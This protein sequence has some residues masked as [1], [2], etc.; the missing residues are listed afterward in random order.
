[1][2]HKKMTLQEI[3]KEAFVYIGNADENGEIIPDG[4][5][6]EAANLMANFIHHLWE[7]D[8]V[9]E[10]ISLVVLSPLYPEH[11]PCNPL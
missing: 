2:E 4:K 1:M 8:V 7:I 3:E 10:P 9:Y 11:D 5:I 6:Y